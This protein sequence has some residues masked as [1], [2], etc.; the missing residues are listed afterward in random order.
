MVKYYILK[1]NIVHFTIHFRCLGTSL[2]Y[3]SDY[4]GGFLANQ[5]AALTLTKGHPPDCNRD[6]MTFCPH[7]WDPRSGFTAPWLQ[8]NIIGYLK[9]LQILLPGIGRTW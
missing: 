6:E 3:D 9:Q 5:E 8:Q 7:G 4:G 2:D 1:D